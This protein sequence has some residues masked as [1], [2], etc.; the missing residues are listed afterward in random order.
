MSIHPLRNGKLLCLLLCLTFSKPHA[1]AQDLT[2]TPVTKEINYAVGGYYQCLPPDYAKSESKKY[3]LIIFIHGIGELGD[4][5]AGQL[6]RVLRNGL[7]KQIEKKAFPNSFTVNGETSSFI[8]ISPQFRKN[9]RDAAVVTSLIDYCVANYRVDESRIYLT[10]LSMG[11]GI[12]WVYAAKKSANSKRLA[13]MLTVCGNTNASAGGV[14]NIATADLA[15]WSTHCSGDPVVPSSNSVN[16]VNGLN[17]Y[18]PA[19]KHKALLTMFDSKGHDAWTKT[20]DPAFKPNGLNVYEWLLMHRREDDTATLPNTPPVAHAGA[21]KTIYLPVNSITLTGS[22]TDADGTIASYAWEQVDGPSKAGIDSPEKASVNI[23]SLLQGSYTFRLTVKDNDGAGDADNVTVTVKPAPNK[24]PIANAGVD[25]TIIL[26]VDS[27]LL[28]GRGSDEDGTAD[29]YE[30]TKVSGTGGVIAAENGAVV[31]V[32]GLKEGNYV[33]RL[34]VTDNDDATTT[35]DIKITVKAANPVMVKAGR[36]TLIYKNQTRPDTAWLNGSASVGGTTPVWRRI[37]G[38]G[39]ITITDSSDLITHA[40]GLQEGTHVFGLSIDGEADTLYVTVRDWQKKNISPCRPGGGKSFV[41]TENHPGGYYLPYI[42]RD[43]KLGEP[44]LGGDTLYFNGGAKTAFEIGDFGGGPDCPVYIMPKNEPLIITDGYFRIGTR[45]SNVVQHAVLDGTALRSKG[46]AYGFFIDNRNVPEVENNFSGLTANWVSHFTVKG[47]RSVNTGVLQIKLD[48]REAPY[49]RYD[50]FIQ[51]RIRIEDNFIDGSKTE[52]MY[53]GHTASNG[54]QSK[55]PYGPPPR[56]DS[57]EI[58]NNIVMNCGWDGIQVSNA[59]TAAVIKHNFI[60]K[61]GLLNQ[62]SQRAGILMGANTTGIIDSNIIINSKGIGIQVLGYGAVKVQGNIV[63]SIY[64]G[65]ANQDGIYQSHIAVLPEIF[66]TPLRVTN[67]GNLISHVERMHIKVANNN[68]DMMAGRTYNNFLIDSAGRASGS[69]ITSGAGDMLNDNEVI[70]RFPFYVA[71]VRIKESTPVISMTQDDAAE[72]FTTIKAT[73]EW[74]FGRLKSVSAANEAPVADAGTDKTI[75]LPLDSIQLIGSGSDKDGSIVAYG[76]HRIAGP[77]ACIINAP[78]ETQ[79]YVSN[80]VEGNYEFEFAVT[81]NG[82]A[83]SRDTVTIVVRA[84]VV[85][86]NNPPVADAG[87]D[88]EV[89]F[90]VNTAVLVG[91][92]WDEDGAVE[93]YQWR[94]LSGPSEALFNE[95]GEARTTVSNLTTGIY[96]IEITVTDDKG[97]IAADTVTIKVKAA[98]TE[99]QNIAPVVTA[100][101]DMNI[102]F[103]E[104]RIDLAGVAADSDGTIASY[105]WRKIEGPAQ[106]TIATP[107]TAQTGISNLT[108]GVYKFELRAA[109]NRGATGRDTIVVTVAAATRALFAISAGADRYVTL[110]YD[111]VMLTGN[112]D[113]PYRVLKSIRWK[114]LSG[115]KE[116]RIKDSKAAQTGVTGLAEGVY[117]FACTAADKVG[118]IHT[119]TV[120]VTVKTLPKSTVALFP[121]PSKDRVTISINAA[122]GAMQ[123]QVVVYN[124]SGRIVHRETFMRTEGKMSRQLNLSAL[125]PGIYII[126]IIADI[127]S[128]ITTKLLKQ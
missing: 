20:Y 13:A 122:T 64:S 49:G 114:K 50:K 12:S 84:E 76:W 48:A 16:W 119:D 38:P 105:Q 19:I 116:Y 99:T 8:I 81:D 87:I 61:N 44:V 72:N 24:A 78:R 23:T 29:L 54:G 85:K 4:G 95:P 6:K 118:N 18:T 22:A 21:S 30:W 98:A 124:T 121:N 5:S 43:T 69:M 100:G 36:D 107:Q 103:P 70:A 97:A 89:L 52:G 90:P 14:S 45:D 83:I 68:G 41:V 59:R 109:D 25:T 1:S 128:K 56:M 93:T 126:E 10:G 82:N 71:A 42:N 2:Q 91:G 46:I 67:T 58:L 125:P 39:A 75:V 73:V 106:Y 88:I 55:N 53:I 80:F 86:E 65:S 63:D 94:Q 127:N 123:T 96:Q 77:G 66:N 51:K 79:T 11:S 3:P 57:V 37:S 111:S 108:E 102:I 7:P 15:V 9:Y 40:T 47:Y 31:W 104:N 28:T 35:D 120:Q 34:S 110:P 33:F 27:V 101:I 60:Y 112:V 92:G 74:L 26:P 62:P 17:A 115:P 113:D 32:N 117:E